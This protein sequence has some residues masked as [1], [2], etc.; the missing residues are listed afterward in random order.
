MAKQ[1]F[2]RCSE[3]LMS[4]HILFNVVFAASSLLFFELN[5]PH[6][7][8]SMPFL[9]IEV[10]LALALLFFLLI[11]AIV[12]ASSIH[13]MSSHPCFC[14]Q[15][16]TES[17]LSSAIILSLILSGS[18][19]FSLVFIYLALGATNGLLLV[20]IRKRMSLQLENACLFH[21]LLK[22]MIIH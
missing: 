22:S 15:I 8:F 5:N 17:A 13:V 12:L 14:C 19:F 10:S 7:P 16:I 1:K 6:Y 9:P 11:L 18:D 20:V 21:K 3:C 2:D 4:S